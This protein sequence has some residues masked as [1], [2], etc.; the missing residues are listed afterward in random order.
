[1]NFIAELILGFGPAKLCAVSTFLTA[2][3]YEGGSIDLRLNL[4][5]GF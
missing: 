4:T 2:A 3:D 1:V 5:Y